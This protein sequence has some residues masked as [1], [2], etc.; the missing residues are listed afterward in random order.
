MLLQE[1]RTQETDDDIDRERELNVY[2]SG[3]APP[4]LDGSL[5]ALGGLSEGEPGAAF[6][7]LPGNGLASKKEVRFDPALSL[8]LLIWCE[9]EPEASSALA[10]KGGLEARPE[11]QGRGLIVGQNWRWEDVF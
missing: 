1:R 11:A 4:T 7:E 9:D 10:H 8:V 5:S 3:S 6:S 2:R